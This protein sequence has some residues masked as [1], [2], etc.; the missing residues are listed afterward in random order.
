MKHRIPLRPTPDLKG[1]KNKLSLSRVNWFKHTWGDNSHAANNSFAC[2]SRFLTPRSILWRSFETTPASRPNIQ[3]LNPA[4]GFIINCNERHEPF[5]V[6]RR[7]ALSLRI[8]MRYSD[9]D[10]NIRSVATT[11]ERKRWFRRTTIWWQDPYSK[12]MT[13]MA[14]QCLWQSNHRSSRR[15]SHQRE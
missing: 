13:Y 3:R 11:M 12:R 10:V 8:V 6:N 2:S 5:S 7:S 1:R 14:P 4:W 15:Q 9:L